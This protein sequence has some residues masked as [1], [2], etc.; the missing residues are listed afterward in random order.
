MHVI[1][2]NPNT[3]NPTAALNMKKPI[4]INK[5]PISKMSSYIFSFNNFNF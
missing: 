2:D 1:I 3:M 5:I 4:E